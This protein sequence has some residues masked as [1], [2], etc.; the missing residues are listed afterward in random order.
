MCSPDFDSDMRWP[1]HLGLAL[2]HSRTSNPRAEALAAL[3]RC[4]VRH[5]FPLELALS[6]SVAY[7]NL[8]GQE[9]QPACILARA[10][11]RRFALSL[12]SIT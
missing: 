3:K 10:P 6:E 11:C 8:H 4:R 1:N 2:G 7:L 5:D 12:H 9:R